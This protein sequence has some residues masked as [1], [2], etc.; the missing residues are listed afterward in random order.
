MLAEHLAPAFV[1]KILAVEIRA[2]SDVD[3][4]IEPSS[5][6]LFV[7]RLSFVLLNLLKILKRHS[8]SFIKHFQLTHF[9]Q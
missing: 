4:K 1:A 3:R 5:V 8:C 2:E 9:N 6:T 7:H